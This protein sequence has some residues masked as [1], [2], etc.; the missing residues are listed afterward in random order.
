M[1]KN[2][3]GRK[4]PPPPPPPPQCPSPASS[5]ALVTSCSHHELKKGA[6]KW[7][8]TSKGKLKNGRLKQER[9][10]VIC[11]GL[12]TTMWLSL[13]LVAAPKVAGT[14]AGVHRQPIM[15]DTGKL[16]RNVPTGH[17][18]S[19]HWARRRSSGTHHRPRRLSLHLVQGCDSGLE[20]FLLFRASR[21]THR[22]CATTFFFFGSS[23]TH[24]LCSCAR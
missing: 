16:R 5:P 9:C 11:A 17:S 8:G 3:F 1:Q 14:L 2:A 4:V 21:H 15:R 19:S 23:P 20:M 18:A 22:R 6:N 7:K 24:C 12:R 13:R 10:L